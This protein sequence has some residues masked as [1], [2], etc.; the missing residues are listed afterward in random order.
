GSQTDNDFGGRVWGGGH[1]LF[2][3]GAGVGLAN[4]AGIIMPVDLVANGW[5][6][7]RFQMRNGLDIVAPQDVEVF[8][9]DAY[10]E[11]RGGQC[12]ARPSEETPCSP[13][14]DFSCSPEGCF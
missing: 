10:S 11:P 14:F 5:H 2:G 12:R 9:T 7:L 1:L 13:S 6:S 3:A 4:E 8:I